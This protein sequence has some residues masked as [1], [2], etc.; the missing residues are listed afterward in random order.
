MITDWICFYYKDRFL[1]QPFPHRIAT[2]SRRLSQVVRQR[3][4]N[5]LSPV[6]IREPP[7]FLP[8]F[9][10]QTSVAIGGLRT[11]PT[12][13]NNYE[14][15]YKDLWNNKVGRDLANQPGTIEDRIN[16]A[17]NNGSIITEQSV[18]KISSYATGNFYIEKSVNTQTMGD[19]KILIN[20]KITKKYTYQIYRNSIPI[21]SGLDYTSTNELEIIEIG[22]NGDTQ[23]E[24]HQVFI[25]AYRSNN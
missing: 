15:M 18:I 3:T 7:C 1:F 19:L 14:E 10:C 2:V 5:S 8:Q 12:V 9:I 16:N 22:Q 4:A 24:H 17:F 23:N 21:P 20:G 6:R 13:A 11:H 25:D